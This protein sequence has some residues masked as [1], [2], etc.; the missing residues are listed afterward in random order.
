[1]RRIPGVRRLLH[2]GPTRRSIVRDVDDEIRFHIETRVD[3]LMAQGHSR[4]DA[5]RIAR[6]EYGDMNAAR[7][8]LTAIDERFAARMA[9]RE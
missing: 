7:D 1:M 5:D 8:E 2:L 6:E 4:S 3:A 9:L